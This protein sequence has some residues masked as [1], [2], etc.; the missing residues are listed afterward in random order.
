MM[1]QRQLLIQQDDSLLLRFIA[2][3]GELRQTTSFWASQ[4]PCHK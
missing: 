4:R 2:K 1:G 3:G